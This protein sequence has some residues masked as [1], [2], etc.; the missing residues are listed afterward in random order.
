LSLRK[1]GGDDAA[2]L[3]LYAPPVSQDPS[4]NRR[5]LTVED[6]RLRCIP[7]T[8]LEEWVSNTSFNVAPP[9]PIKAFNER[10]SK[11]H[12]LVSQKDVERWLEIY[13]QG[14]DA[15]EALASFALISLLA[16]ASDPADTTGITHSV[17]QE[18]FLKLYTAVL[19]N[20]KPTYDKLTTYVCGELLNGTCLLKLWWIPHGKPIVEAMISYVNSLR[21]RDWKRDPGRTPS[22]LPDV[23][24]WHLRLLDY[25]WPDSN[26]KD[27][28]RERKCKLF[29]TQLS[30]FVD[31]FSGSPIYHDKL[32]QLEAYLAL[33]VESS[34]E[35]RSPNRQV[36]RSLRFEKRDPLRGALMN[37]GMI[38][39]I[40]LGDITE[41]RLSWFM[42]YELL[43]VEVAGM[44]VAFVGEEDFKNVD[45][46][47]RERLKG[48]VESWKRCENEG[49]RREAWEIEERY[50]RKVRDK[51][52]L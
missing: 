39:E 2:G 38:T 40:F 45:S 37:N 31:E 42:G 51:W 52:G 4:V 32:S 22:V 36:G 27:K 19:W 7:R 13:G 29:A 23:F 48:M 26:D 6:S 28:D 33:D 20:D 9:V 12:T 18:Q 8:V 21:T 46:D 5:V 11:D 41:T 49:V 43:K 14:L 50:R 25:P 47:V 1:Y 15:I 16:H 24:F 10:L 34:T 17:I 44:L 35:D 3:E 30:A